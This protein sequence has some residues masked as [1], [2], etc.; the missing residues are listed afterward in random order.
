MRSS[1]VIL[2]LLLLGGVE[3][4]ACPM[5]SYER[6]LD[7]YPKLVLTRLAIV[8]FLVVNRL[9]GVRVLGA[10]VLYEIFW[11]HAYRY[12]LWYA[13]PLT[14]N[15][16]LRSTAELG[17]MLLEAGAFGAW[18]LYWLGKVQFFQRQPGVGVPWWQACF[19]IPLALFTRMVI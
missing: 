7:W 10:F 15:I 11:Y 8:P 4:M 18:L 9:D 6:M 13:F 2:C 12:G 17:L 1:Y 16:L 14:D 19:Y 3:V 5:C